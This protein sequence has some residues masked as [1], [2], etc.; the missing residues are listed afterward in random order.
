M[1]A[2]FAR[3]LAL[4][5]ALAIA[6]YVC[7]SM[8]PPFLN[9]LLWALVLTVLFT[10][11]HRR[12]RTKLGSPALTAA[13]STLLVVVTILAPSTF[14]TIAVVAETGRIAGARSSEVCRCSACSGWSSGRCSWRSRWHSSM[15]SDR[16]T[17]HPPRPVPSPR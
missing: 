15:C 4:L 16:R 10:P 3:T 6:L 5:V 2:A 11:V 13:V 1:T 17:G 7:W 12:L 8:V 9:V 14:I